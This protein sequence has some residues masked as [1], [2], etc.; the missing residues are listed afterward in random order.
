MNLVRERGF[1]LLWGGQFLGVLADWSL[2]T[3]LL[4]WVYALT[5]SGFAVSLVGLAEALPLL[6]LAPVAGV[7]VDRWSRAY[8][9]AGS[10]LA[11]AAVS[12][13]LLTVTGRAGLPL[14]L[15]VT[16]LA[17]AASQFFLPA[18]SAAVPV[19]VGPERA[20][21]AN[22]LLSL[23]NGVIAAVGPAG[24]A[25]LFATIG[26]RGAVLALIGVYILTAPILAAVPAPRP[27][28][29]G[30]ARVPVLREM[31]DGLR[32]V[33]RSRLLVAL[34]A[35]AFVALLGVGALSVLDVVF[36]TRALHLRSE[37]VGALFLASGMGQVVGGL[38]VAALSAR[39]ARRYHLL[40]GVSTVVNGLALL[41][42][43]LAP[44]LPVAVVALV[45]SG[46][47]FPP[48]IVS[49]MTLAQ[50]AT[51]D[52]YM[53]RVMS[54]INTGMA[55]AMIASMTFGGALT[56]IFGVRQVIGVGAALLAASGVLSLRTI[57][58]TPA[59]RPLPVD[60]PDTGSRIAVAV[61]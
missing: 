57:R 8:T 2:R 7:F 40:L 42:Y 15:A 30:E 18:A 50:L 32:Y 10:V 61:R 49:F 55:V 14:I 26:P 37:T 6:L 47:S 38:V 11:R 12:L 3:L 19:V 45:A 17:N 5:R 33:R 52:L 31:A 58:A 41:G 29:S 35:V 36:V 27:A 60:E 48:L 34:I 51:D 13:P 59:P 46:L 1:A 4:I 39:A 9:M 43:A 24:A 21:Q 16:L 22:S 28:E 44:S 23:A 56:D 20:G 53:G 54:L 25:L